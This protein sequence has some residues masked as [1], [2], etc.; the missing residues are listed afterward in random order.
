MIPVPE[1]DLTPEEMIL[2]ASAMV[3][4]LRERQ[5]DCERLGRIPQIM[6]VLKT[7]I[8]AQT[9][10]GAESFGREH[11]SQTQTQLTFIN[12]GEQS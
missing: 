2:R 1:P 6:A 5:A 4:T 10:R 7:H 12:K 8:A 11:L 3:P 9:D